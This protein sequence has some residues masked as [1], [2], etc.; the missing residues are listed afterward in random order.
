MSHENQFHAKKPD[1]KP[2]L[3]SQ[4]MGES[5]YQLSPLLQ[6]FHSGK[7]TLIG[8]A[9]VEGGNGLAK[10]ICLVMRFPK[11]NSSVALRV[12]CDHQLDSMILNRQFGDHLMC[13]TFYRD[14]IYL[15]ERLNGLS[16]YLKAVEQDGV[17]QYQFYRAKFLGIPMPKFLYPQ[18]KAYE[19]EV[20]QKYYFFVDVSMCLIG[21]VIAYSG[22]LSISY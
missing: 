14:G 11:Q 20:D 8:E 19:Q 22:T 13:S 18:V 5:F 21:R 3:L 7:T 15:V 4:H 6:R 16:L 1:A 10:L 9:T 2:N 12:D 17:L